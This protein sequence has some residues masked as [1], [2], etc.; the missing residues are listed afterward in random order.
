MSVVTFLFCTFLCRCLSIHNDIDSPRGRWV[1]IIVYA[2]HRP[3]GESISLCTLVTDHSVSPY[4]CVRLSPTTRWVY[5]I[6][7]ACHRPLGESGSLCTL[8]TEHSVSLCH[9]VRLSP[10]T[11]WVCHCVRLSLTTRWVYHCVRL[12]LTTR[13]VS[14]CA[15]V[16]DG[17]FPWPSEAEL[18]CHQVVT[19]GLFCLSDCRLP[20]VAFLFARVWKPVFRM[21]SCLWP[22]T[23][24]G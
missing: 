24:A 13:C 2:C 12:S 8:V 6:V 14:L 16:T 21:K 19:M 17:A 18:Q 7:Y 5:I 3:L 15:L 4:H 9:W 10:T 23:S 20:A 11:R 22:E 1:Y